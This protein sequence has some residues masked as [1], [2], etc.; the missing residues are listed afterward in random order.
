[1]ATLYAIWLGRLDF[2]GRAKALASAH[3][4][5]RN[6][7][8]TPPTDQQGDNMFQADTCCTLVPYFDVQ[9]GQL[10][11]FKALRP[12]FVAKT[13]TESGCLHYAFSYNGNIAHC[14]DRLRER[15]GGAGPFGERG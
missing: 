14:R 12:K 10:D 3:K 6:A 7:I 9:E 13:Q 8:R 4:Q 15:R 5:G 1:M 2:A 11:A